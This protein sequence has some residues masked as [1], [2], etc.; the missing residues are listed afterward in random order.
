MTAQGAADGGWAAEQAAQRA[1][2]AHLCGWKV[3]GCR[4]FGSGGLDVGNEALRLARGMCVFA[5]QAF[6]DADEA[7]SKSELANLRPIYT[8]NMFDGV[9][10]LIALAKYAFEGEG[11]VA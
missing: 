8:A 5:E 1:A 7:G 10:M 2:I 9:G 6:R 3:D 11:A 4:P